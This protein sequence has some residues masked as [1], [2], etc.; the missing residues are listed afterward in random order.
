MFA[1]YEERLRHLAGEPALWSRPCPPLVPEAQRAAVAATNATDAPASSE[2]LHTLFEAQAA[3]APEGTAVVTPSRT[4]TYLELDA[5]SSQVSIRLLERGA[6]VGSLIAVSMEKG[7][8]QIV[9]VLAVLK[10][11]AAYLPLDPSLP[12]ERRETLLA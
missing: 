1:A 12:A 4:L 8:E 9:A 6:D 2:R 3:R 7:W 11:G 5:L 10:A